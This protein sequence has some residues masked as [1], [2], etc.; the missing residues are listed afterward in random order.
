MGFIQDVHDIK[1][2]QPR[3]LKAIAAVDDS[4]VPAIA[5]ATASAAA[6][7][8][9]CN[10]ALDVLTQIA[11]TLTAIAAVQTAMAADLA[12]IKAEVIGPPIT[13]ITVV[14]TET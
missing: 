8:A 4:I 1:E 9:S 6:A 14:E 7:A 12:A 11:S 2:A 13:G 5:A 10:A 3:I